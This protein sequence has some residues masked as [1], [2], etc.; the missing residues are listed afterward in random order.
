MPLGVGWMIYKK[1]A[2]VYRLELTHQRT[3]AL[4]C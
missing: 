2:N 3:F 1:Q 4:L